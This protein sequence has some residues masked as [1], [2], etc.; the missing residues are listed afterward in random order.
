M[1]KGKALFRSKGPVGTGSPCLHAAT[2]RRRHARSVFLP[3]KDCYGRRMGT[4]DGNAFLAD[5]PQFLE[6]EG[7]ADFSR[8]RPLPD[9]W[10]L[11]LADIVDSTGAIAAGRYK[12]VNMAGASLI[13]AVLNSLGRLDL[14][15]VFGGDGAFVA[16]PPSGIAAA[17]IALGQ[18]KN[19]VEREFALQMR[20]A[21]VPVSDIRAAGLDVRIARFRASSEMSYA[22][23]AG[24]G[25]SWAEERMKQGA[26][27][28][29]GAVDD[30]QP[31]LTGLSCRWNPIS[32]RNGQIVSVIAVP[33][34]K[35]SGE[36]FQRLLADV[37]A[38]AG[39]EDRAGHPVPP[40]GPE[41]KLQLHGVDAASLTA[42]GRIG[43]LRS[44]LSILAMSALLIVLHRFNLKLGR[45]DIRLYARD[46][47]QNTDFRKFDDALKMTLDIDAPRL[48][49]L[50]AR[51]EDAERA[52]DCHY[53]LHLQGQALMTCIVPSPMSR[54]HM[55]F[56]DGATGGY[57]EAASRLKQKLR[58]TR[59]ASSA[60]PGGIGRV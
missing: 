58:E 47:S 8:Y 20:T 55:H 23:F 41:L 12:S 31:D 52:G 13:T 39:T 10:A 42:P 51:L 9:G 30:N 53:G 7:I 49:K 38:L 34:T 22:M 18:V 4:I 15:F 32:S 19:W 43:R 1:R 59:D 26:Y 6:F 54:D 28:V 35:G 36:A 17:E 40:D 11:A 46:V 48:K 60:G 14:P 24:G 27:S 44:R 33:G 25:A 29:A 57:A 56:V 45:F 50:E 37:V 2:S 5:L 16:V 21:I 3:N